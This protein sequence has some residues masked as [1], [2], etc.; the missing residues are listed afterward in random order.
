MKR[1]D[2]Q[3]ERFG[4]WKVLEVSHSVRRTDCRSTTVL[5]WKCVCDCGTIQAVRGHDLRNGGTTS[6]G[7]RRK[8]PHPWKRKHGMHNCPTYGSWR[9]MRRRCLNTSDKDYP[10]WG[11]RGIT[12]CERWKNLDTG[13]QNFINDMGERPE[14][15]SLDRFPNNQGNYEPTNCRWATP[16]EQV[17]NQ[18]KRKR[19]TA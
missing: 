3:G 17:L 7:C 5:W 18:A 2:I 11:G 16:R 12:I 19:A 1:K 6:C 15:K 13:F 14:G 10:R 9:A 4:Y 8:E